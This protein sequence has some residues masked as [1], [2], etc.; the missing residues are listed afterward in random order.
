MDDTLSKHTEAEVRTKP[1]ED[2]RDAFGSDLSALI[3]GHDV[4]GNMRQRNREFVSS[5]KHG[6][7]WKLV[8]GIPQPPISPLVLPPPLQP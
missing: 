6:K 7:S 3:E 8:S 1:L 4:D 5:N 2:V